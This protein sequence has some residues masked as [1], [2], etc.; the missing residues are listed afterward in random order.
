MVAGRLFRLGFD[1]WPD[2]CFATKRAYDRCMVQCRKEVEMSDS[3]RTHFKRFA[4]LVKSKAD[5]GAP[6][7]KTPTTNCCRFS[8]GIG[9]S[10]RF[11]ATDDESRA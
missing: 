11:W 10:L 1:Y 7:A 6:T 3:D 9:A 2:P 5:V 4:A 8:G